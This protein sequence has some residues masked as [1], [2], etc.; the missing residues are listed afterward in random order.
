M[1]S[2]KENKFGNIY[3]DPKFGPM[4]RQL[5]ALDLPSA[6]APTNPDA[7][8]EEVTGTGLV[9]TE[10][11]NNACAT[12]SADAAPKGAPKGVVG[13]AKV[14]V[15]DTADAGNDD[16]GNVLVA[17]PEGERGKRTRV[18]P[19]VRPPA[20][21]LVRPSARKR[22][23]WK[24]LILLALVLVVFVAMAAYFMPK[25][26][27][28]GELEVAPPKPTGHAPIGPMN[29][30]VVPTVTTTKPDADNTATPSGLPRPSAQ[31]SARPS[32]RVWGSAWVAPSAGGVAPDNVA[33]DDV[34]P[35]ASASASALVV[36]P[37][38]A[39][40]EEPPE[41]PAEEPAPKPS[42]TVDLFHQ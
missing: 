20:R 31:P 15:A 5:D 4:M 1:S 10:G 2:P 17:L 25:R 3:D 26:L 22:Q 12:V 28:G 6:Y 30:D 8:P 18:M 23:R 36:E 32:A 19:A 16:E 42:T 38:E 9:S 13:G 27:P 41:E 35:A 29:A 33:P 21:P 7:P 24:T 39:T 14:Q 40:P 34:T 37:P 11:H